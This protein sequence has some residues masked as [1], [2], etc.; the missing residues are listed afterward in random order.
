[1]RGEDVGST[2]DAV[3][4]DDSEPLHNPDDPALDDIEREFDRVT[5]PEFGASHDVDGTT[6][7][8]SEDIHDAAPDSDAHDAN[9]GRSGGLLRDLLD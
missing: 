5:D 9:S 2:Y 7:S 3:E 1:M 8:G 6:D 4:P